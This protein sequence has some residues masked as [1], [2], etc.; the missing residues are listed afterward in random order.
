[1][2][3]FLFRFQVNSRQFGELTQLH[4]QD[5]NGL[6]LSE[7]E[8]LA[9][10]RFFGSRSVFTGA[11]HLDDFVNDVERLEAT[12]QNVVAFV[13]FVQPELATACDDFDLM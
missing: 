1:M 10:Q 12:F 5:V 11:N 4:V 8:L 9:H 6:S 2:N 7:T 3:L 13:G